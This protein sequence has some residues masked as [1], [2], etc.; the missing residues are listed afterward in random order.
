MLTSAELESLGI[1]LIWTIL[2]WIQEP[3]N[4]EICN[5]LLYFKNALRNVL[6]TPVTPVVIKN[7]YY[8]NIRFIFFYGRSSL[9]WIWGFGVRS[10]YT[11]VVREKL[12]TL[13]RETPTPTNLSLCCR[14]RVGGGAGPEERIHS[15]GRHSD[16]KRG[17]VGGEV[18]FL[19]TPLCLPS[20]PLT[21]SSSKRSV[22]EGCN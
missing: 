6:W 8:P 10:L 9:L 17:L 16:G 2:D 12:S 18:F 1:R 13:K 14:V 7:L 22:K 5:V 11:V 19:F 21:H 20:L 15:A 4:S 3:W